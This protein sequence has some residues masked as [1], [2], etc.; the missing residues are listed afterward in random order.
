MNA[1]I[2]A[3][4][5][6]ND[7]GVTVLI[8]LK[9]WAEREGITP[10]TARQKAARGAIPA[11]KMGRDWFIDDSISNSDK[12]VKSGKYVDWRKK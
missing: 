8:P 3:N 9:Q 1:G 4:G 12:R 11:K 7:R 10:A 5:F 6:M 2:S